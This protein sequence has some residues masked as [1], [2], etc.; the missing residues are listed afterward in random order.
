MI[1][2]LIKADYAQTSPGHIIEA[3]YFY[4]DTE[5]DPES[6]LA[7]VYGGFEKC[8]SDFEIKRNNYPWYI[9]EC[10]LKGHCSLTVKSQTYSLENGRLAGIAPGDSHHYKCDFQN[11]MEHVFVA[12]T[13][14]D[15]AELFKQS[16]IGESISSKAYNHERTLSLINTLLSAGF[17]K[18][19]YSQQLCACYLKTL[20]LE[21]ANESDRT[22]R[23]HSQS[24]K[25][26][27][28]CRSYIDEHFS[29]VI[30][31]CEVADACGINVRY[32]SRL[33]KR[34]DDRTPQEYIIQLKLNKAATLLL[35]LDLSVKDV[36]LYVGFEDQYH[37]SRSFKKLYGL[38][39][40]N[41]RKA[42]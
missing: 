19:H 34:F 21:L 28:R 5:P 14:K 32:M 10:P 36:S 27:R 40:Q 35:T 18:S 15:A 20:L 22:G 23:H 31:P 24:E 7:V 25:C 33:F 29:Q 17:E 16:G 12:F 26:Y 37:F 30:L 11:P 13:G 3:R 2:D 8:A 6:E 39:P 38:S 42:D 1:T 9:L 4:F 41:Y